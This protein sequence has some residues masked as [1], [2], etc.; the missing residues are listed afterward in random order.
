MAYDIKQLDLK[1]HKELIITQ[2]L[3]HGDLA[4][5]RWLY[6]TYGE[7]AI[8]KVVSRPRRGL[9]FA[10]VLNFWVQMPGLKIDP[11]I[12]TKAIIKL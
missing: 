8:N 7:A 4:A 2:L 5:V 12:Y 1:K 11:L 3:N 9:W 10:R 6:K